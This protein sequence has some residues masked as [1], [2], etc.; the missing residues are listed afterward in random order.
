M[1]KS[2]IQ[3]IG[4]LSV[5]II[6]LCSSVLAL[7]VTPGMT[8]IKYPQDIGRTFQFSVLGSEG[9]SVDFRTSGE[10]ANYIFL[11]KE[12]YTFRNRESSQIFYY[13]INIPANYS[14][15]G[16][17]RGEIII[18]ESLTD[19]EVS[20]GAKMAVVSEVVFFIPYPYKY[21]ESA[22]DITE[23]DKN[24]TTVFLIPVV[25][26]G[27]ETINQVGA[28]VDIYKNEERI[29]SVKTDFISLPSMQRSEISANWQANVSIGNYKAKITIFYDDIVVSYWKDFKVG[30]LSLD[31]FDLFVEDFELGNIVTMDVLVENKWGEPLKEVYANLILSNDSGVVVDIKSAPYDINAT[32]KIRIPLY[33]DTTGIQEGKYTGDII[34][35]H[36]EFASK[37]KIYV[38]ISNYG[39]GIE[40]E[41]GVF[42]LDNQSNTLKAIL[43][44]LLLFGIILLVLYKKFGGIIGRK[45]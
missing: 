14:I 10:L 4:I 37:K 42:V 40:L 35:N 17:H 29:D 21:L 31:I 9:K 24:G 1:K 7:G 22:V 20:F 19:S 41:S 8:T 39:I 16:E 26:K 15:P 45:R 33:W 13:T 43:I 11:Q 2:K 12:N 18:S 36:K 3:I 28:V 5:L 25:N 27:S 44:G 30:N 6:F 23:S 38:D 34:I 32:S